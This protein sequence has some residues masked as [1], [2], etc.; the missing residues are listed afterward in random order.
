MSFTKYNYF[1]HYVHILLLLDVY[2]EHN[3]LSKHKWYCIKTYVSLKLRYVVNMYTHEISETSF[4]TNTL[5]G[6]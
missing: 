3:S 4:A 1:K 6:V 5:D 2:R